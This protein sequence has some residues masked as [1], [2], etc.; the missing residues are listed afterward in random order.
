MIYKLSVSVGYL[1]CICLKVAKKDFFSNQ[2]NAKKNTAAGTRTLF[3]PPEYGA[4]S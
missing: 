2:D 3:W 1:T 4:L